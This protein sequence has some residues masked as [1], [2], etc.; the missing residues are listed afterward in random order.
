MTFEPLS[1][2]LLHTLEHSLSP[3]QRHSSGHDHFPHPSV[4]SA[5][6]PPS[7][8]SGLLLSEVPSTPLTWLWPARIP[9]GHLTLL[10]AAPGCNPSLFAITL[11]ASISSGSPLPDGTPTT[12]GNVILFAPYDS[13]SATLK[14]CLQAAGGDPAHVLLFCPSH[15][16]TSS[17]SSTF[18]QQ[19]GPATTST[20]A[21]FLPRDLPQ[22]AALIR[23]IDARL[24]I[25]D[26]AS[27]I[28]GLR[29]PLLHRRHPHPPLAW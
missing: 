13:A 11:A 3:N 5:A 17:F 7:S 14:P 23:L 24:L 20:H 28:P 16:P 6:A 1:D 9:L 21:F 19:L 27:A 25:L 29:Y 12:Q 18:A 22:V 8:L 26:P 4:P 15:S 2:H 10:D